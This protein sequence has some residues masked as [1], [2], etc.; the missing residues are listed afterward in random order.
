MVIN[1]SEFDLFLIDKN[2]NNTADGSSINWS[3]NSEELGYI[4][5]SEI[6]KSLIG[7]K[8]PTVFTR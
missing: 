4:M 7:F 6:Y 8:N 2:I 5:N 1:Q 3:K